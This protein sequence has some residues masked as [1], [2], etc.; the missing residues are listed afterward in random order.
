MLPPDITQRL[1]PEDGAIKYFIEFLLDYKQGDLEIGKNSSETIK[2]VTQSGRTNSVIGIIDLDK[3][4]PE[5]FSSFK[6]EYVK[7]ERYLILEHSTYK[8]KR[9]L[10][11]LKPPY[12]QFIYNH[13]SPDKD[14]HQNFLKNF[15][16][17]DFFKKVSKGIRKSNPYF[18][19]Y[20][21][22]INGLIKKKPPLYEDEIRKHILKLLS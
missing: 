11:C 13:L 20:K 2:K 21:E 8:N 19:K 18:S 3:I 9:F 14:Y 12:E 7:H 10:I 1:F 6:K 16:D 22:S 17:Y 5:S 15:S 4:K